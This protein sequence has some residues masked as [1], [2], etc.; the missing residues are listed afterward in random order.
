[1]GKALNPLGN[2]TVAANWDKSQTLAQNYRRLGL[3]ARLRGPTGGTEKALG[4]KPSHSDKDPLA[5]K[6]IEPVVALA[7]AKVERDADGKII[8]VLSRPNPLND[9]L[10]A[11]S[12]D[13]E[14][15]MAEARNTRSGVAFARP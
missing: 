7:E 1:M 6:N 12:D 2:S 15:A 5:V 3:S 10:T 9:P 13:E 8:R 14:E 4:S 11:L